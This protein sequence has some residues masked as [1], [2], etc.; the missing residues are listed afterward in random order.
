MSKIFGPVVQQGYVVPDAQEGIQHWLAR[1][2]GPFFVEQLDD[3]DA[4]V[5]GK[6][7]KLNLTAAFAYS[8]D[9]QIEVIEPR[10]NSSSIYDDYLKRHPDGGLQH[11]AVW[12]DDIDSKLAELEAAGNRYEVKQRYGDGHAY[13][14]SVDRPGIMIQLMAHNEAIDELFGIIKQAAD[15][16]D[17]E[18]D[19]IRKI[20]WSTGR[21][22]VRAA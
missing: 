3:F 14:E 18:T 1:G 10:G 21:P 9:Q 19:P 5:D 13:I 6:S 15:S 12:V 11:L 17:G 7:V 2:I 4:V 16:W 8:G 20:D 22:V